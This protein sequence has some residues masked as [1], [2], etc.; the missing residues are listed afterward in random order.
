[1]TIRH[2][3]ISGGG[4]SMIQS[5]GAIQQLAQN[6]IIDLNN[7]VSIYGTSAGAILGAMLCLQFDWT[8]LTDYILLRPWQDVFPIKVQNILDAYSKRGIFDRD[9]VVKCFKPLL[10]AKDISL[11][12]TLLEF[13]NITHVDLHMFAFD[14]NHF[15][16]DDIS[17]TSHPSLSLID[18]LHATSSIPIL[19]APVFIGDKCYIDGGII[20]NYPLKPC[21]DSGKSEE[22]IL[23]F[24]NDYDN[25]TEIITDQSTLLEFLLYFILNIIR[26]MGISHL[27]PKIKYELFSKTQ[28]LNLS[29]INKALSS[30]EERKRLFELGAQNGIQFTI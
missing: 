29:V 21:L 4:P 8:V 6:Q 28:C 30:Q 24:N 19:F 25:I 10:D 22:D 17:H 1:M 9:V 11:D 2:L 23:G 26:H 20:N 5:L 7:I 15:Q 27:Q 14:V 18:A 12:V 13:F 3:V 16:L